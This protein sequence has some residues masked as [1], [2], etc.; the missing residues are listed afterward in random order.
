[1]KI[2]GVHFII[3]KGATAYEVQIGRFWIT[4]THLKGFRPWWRRIQLHWETET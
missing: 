1:M 4:L 3:L 2:Y